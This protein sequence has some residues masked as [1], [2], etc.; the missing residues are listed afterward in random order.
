MK[1]PNTNLFA[2]WFFLVQMVVQG[3]VVET[4]RTLLELLGAQTAEGSV[5]ARLV[6]ALLLMF[7]IYLVVYFRRSLP[8]QGKPEGNG[9]NIG[10]RL[11]LAGNVLAALLFV[12]QFFES[13]ITDHN[14]H[15]LLVQFTT[16]CGYLAM[17]LIAAGFSL[18][19]QSSLPQE[20]K[21]R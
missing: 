7:A 15:L 2:A 3:W 12:F 8:P 11:L 5:P 16:A 20:E 21:T 17:G 6:G 13:G 14:T 19:Y 18:I 9:F 4:G 1:F 10:H